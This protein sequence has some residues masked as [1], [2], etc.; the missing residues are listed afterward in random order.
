[1]SE[2]TAKK[3]QSLSGTWYQFDWN[4]I[5]KKWPDIRQTGARYPVDP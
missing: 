5:L 2:Q 3:D 1:M 4:R